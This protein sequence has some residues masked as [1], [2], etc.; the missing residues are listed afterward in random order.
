M[1]GDR[2][3]DAQAALSAGL[4]AVIITPVQRATESTVPELS[5]AT[6][7]MSGVREVLRARDIRHTIRSTE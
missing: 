5:Y 4:R 3:T 6:S 7:L 1:L 2:A